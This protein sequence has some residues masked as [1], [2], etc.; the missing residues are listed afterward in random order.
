MSFART[1]ALT[2]VLSPMMALAEE[3]AITV[4]KAGVLIDG[5]GAPPVRDAVILIEGERIKAVGPGLPVPAGA[6]TI[7]LGSS[8]VL[9]GF[10]DAHTHISAPLVGTPGWD[11]LTPR[12]TVADVALRGAGHARQTLEAGFTT[13]REVGASGFSDVSL[14]NAIRSGWLVGPRMQ[15][16][17]HAIGITGGHCDDSG[18]APKAFG[19]EPGIAEGIANGTEEIRSTIRYQVKYGADVIKICATGGVMSVGDTA[20]AQQY[21]AEELRV[22]VETAHMLERKIT[23]HAHG[24]EGIK[25]AVRAGVDSIEHGSILDEEGARLMAQK[26]T[27]LVSTLTAGDAVIRMAHDGRITGEYAQKA[28]AVAPNMPRSIARAA[29]AGV[30]IVLGTDNIFEPHTTDAREYGLLVAAGLTPMQAIV[31]GASTAAGHLGWAK[32][33]GAVVPGRFADLVAVEGD[34][35]QDIHRLE[36]V[37]FVMK[38]GVVVKSAGPPQDRAPSPR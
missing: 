9:P 3:A 18:W 16:A 22:A 4:V 30:K 33:V 38:G 31:A 10:I 35:L 34:P 17:A 2:L 1:F 11:Q 12:E 13:I 20:G 5:T 21:T 36:R 28:L 29:A 37:H 26:G 6:R 23:A 27:A 8:T 7:D 24:T 15:V 32:D 19:F 25:A 14:R